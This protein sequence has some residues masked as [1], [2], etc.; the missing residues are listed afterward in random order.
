MKR[1]WRVKYGFNLD[2]RVSIPEEELEKA[3][4]ARYKGIPVKLGENYINGSN[5]ISIS[6]D[7][8]KY[9]GWYPSYEPKEA[10]DFKQIE[11]DCPDFEGFMDYFTA[12]VRFLMENNKENLIGQNIEIPQ[13][14]LKK[15]EEKNDNGF[16][17]LS[18]GLD[19]YEDKYKQD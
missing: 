5:I 9:T 8:H 4:Y 11:R 16:K 12:R 10:E 15:R 7:Y 2:E 6:P 17:K 14:E 19:D 3:I 1:Y 13:I 18:D